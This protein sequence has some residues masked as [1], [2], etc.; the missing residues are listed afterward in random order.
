MSYW[1]LLSWY[2]FPFVFVSE[3]GILK[4]DIKHLHKN[5]TESSEFYLSYLKYTE[6]LLLYPVS[7]LKNVDALLCF[8]KG[9]PNIWLT[10][11]SAYDL[12]F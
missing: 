8:V 2:P 12:E 3:C 11:L 1:S 7:E 6:A 5:G 9:S 10:S 4:L